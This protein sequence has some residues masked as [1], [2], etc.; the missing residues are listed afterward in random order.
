MFPLYSLGGG[1]GGE[2]SE[3]SFC[4]CLGAT[5][6]FLDNQEAKELHEQPKEWN[7][8]TV[9]EYCRLRALQ[10]REN[11]L[12]ERLK[13]STLPVNTALSLSLIKFIRLSTYRLADVCFVIANLNFTK[14][15]NSFEEQKYLLD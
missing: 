15:L 2:E 1:G 9:Q 10:S 5:I 3:Q 12:A 14:V 4:Q 8:K 6:L 11:N 7:N 13:A